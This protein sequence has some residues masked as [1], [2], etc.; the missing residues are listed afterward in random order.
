MRSV[1]IGME[2]ALA[3]LFCNLYRILVRVVPCTDDQVNGVDLWFKLSKT[4][5]W[6]P[7]K[8]TYDNELGQISSRF[9]HYS[10]SNK[11][12]FPHKERIQRTDKVLKDV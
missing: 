1:P 2:Q 3:A 8:E 6:F 12:S 7:Q 9:I 11:Q 10:S 5:S 4:E